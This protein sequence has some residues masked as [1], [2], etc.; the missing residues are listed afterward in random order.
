MD[1]KESKIT[2]YFAQKSDL[3]PVDF[4]IGIGDDMAQMRFG[5]LD[6]ALITTDM[7]LDGTHFDTNIHSLE[8]IG[9][10]SM[11]ASLSDCA[12][13][14]TI[15]FAAVAA[16]ALPLDFS[17]N[18][19]KKLHSGIIK[20]GD[21]FGCKLIGGDITSWSIPEGKL[22]VNITML[23]KPAK[24][25]PVRRSTAQIG[26]A[27]C[28]TGFLGGSLE[29][30]HIC[31]VPRVREALE[32]ARIAKPTAMMDISDGISTDLTHLTRLSNV[33]AEL[34]EKLIPISSAAMQKNNPLQAAL[35][36]GEDFELLFTLSPADYENLKTN[37]NMET[38]ISRIGTITRQGLTIK[39]KSGK[40]ENIKP[41]GFDHMK[42]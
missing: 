27:V 23:S 22:A 35:N 29:G 16:V 36:D 26:D 34:E 15:P 7:L 5:G 28:V 12:S 42:D 4:P 2:G 10:K 18:D 31:F 39:L 1:T 40:L 32:I 9:Y 30:K 8:D 25:E 37:W 21:M 11:A 13:M 6:S 19:L 20:S 14:A 41:S 24:T 38:P 17:S 3:D 33:G